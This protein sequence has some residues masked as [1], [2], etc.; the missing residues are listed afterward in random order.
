MF[1][2]EAL[3]YFTKNEL[4][5][6]GSGI[7]KIDLRFAAALPALREKWGKPIT[8]NSVCRTPEHNAKVGGHPSSLH[9]TENPVRKTNGTM[10]ADLSWANWSQE[11]RIKLARLA[12]NMGFAVG[13]HNSFI[14]I[15]LRTAVGLN[16]TVFLY[17]AWS[18]FS[19]QEVF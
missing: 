6:K 12:Y 18:G 1:W 13:L 17:G 14:H 7:I 2:T 16:K 19:P 4:A 9:L 10:A 5:C 15:D 8:V 3:P 11:E